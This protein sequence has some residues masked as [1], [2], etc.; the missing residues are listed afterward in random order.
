MIGGMAGSLLGGRNLGRIK[1]MLPGGDGDDDGRDCEPINE[2]EARIVIRAMCNSAK[3][4]GKIDDEEMESIIGQLDGLDG[5]DEAFFRGELKSR[6]ISAEDMADQTPSNLG[7]EVY[8]VSTMSIHADNEAETSY[9]ADLAIALG[10]DPDQ[11][12]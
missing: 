5:D 6:F 9:L 1:S 7:I 10:V 11:F 4:D 3:S 8:A 12:G 2:D